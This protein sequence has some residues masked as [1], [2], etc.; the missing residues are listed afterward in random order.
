MWWTVRGTAPVLVGALVL[1]G[2]SSTDEPVDY[3]SG[4]RWIIPNQP[5]V[6]I[7]GYTVQATVE[8]GDTATVSVSDAA[9]STGRATLD[10]GERA[11]I[12]GL[13]VTLVGVEDRSSPDDGPGEPSQAV[14]VLP[15]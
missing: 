4:T 6:E 5:P 3:P 8:D 13:T 9:G 10:V 14:L 7:D 12:D 2:C 15:G 11:T 1:A